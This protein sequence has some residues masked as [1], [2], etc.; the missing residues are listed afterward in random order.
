ML[1][2]SHIFFIIYCI[3]VVSNFYVS[4]TVVIS[5]P[6]SLVIPNFNLNRMNNLWYEQ[7]QYLERIYPLFEPLGIF[8]LFVISFM[9]ILLLVTIFLN[10]CKSV[11]YV[12]FTTN[13][14]LNRKKKVFALPKFFA[15]IIDVFLSAVIYFV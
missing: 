7:N 15:V 4:I 10:L 2:L 1:L 14:T 9:F 3:Y 13:L 5:P 8:N 11:R 6:P 12:T